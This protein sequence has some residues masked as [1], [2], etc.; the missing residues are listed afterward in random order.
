MNAAQPVRQ[1]FRVFP[2]NRN[3]R[4]DFFIS[5]SFFFCEYDWPLLCVNVRFAEGTNNKAWKGMLIDPRRYEAGFEKNNLF[6]RMERFVFSRE[7]RGRGGGCLTWTGILKRNGYLLREEDKVLERCHRSFSSSHPGCRVRENVHQIFKER[8]KEEEEE[9]VNYK[10]VR[11]DGQAFEIW[12]SNRSVAPSPCYP[13][14]ARRMMASS[15]RIRNERVP[16]RTRYTTPRWT[17]DPSARDSNDFEILLYFFPL[18]K[19]WQKFI[20]NFLLYADGIINARGFDWKK[21]WIKRGENWT[22]GV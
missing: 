10:V 22:F 17:R 16:P 6:R 8:E 14:L 2:W 15:K 21:K 5:V 7:G 12:S 4:V 9:E 19:I 20:R 11:V 3:M 18:R 1:V 13:Q